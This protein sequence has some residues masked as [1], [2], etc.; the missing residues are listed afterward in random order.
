[1]SRDPQ[2]YGDTVT[3]GAP[4]KAVGKNSENTSST[5]IQEYINQSKNCSLQ[6]F[7]T[8]QSIRMQYEL[9]EGLH[10]PERKKR[11]LH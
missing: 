5:E 11:Q 3:F 10:G 1:M 4:L 7:S 8:T 6:D 9:Y 2:K